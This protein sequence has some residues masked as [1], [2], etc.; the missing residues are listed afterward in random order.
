MGKWVSSAGVKTSTTVRSA[1]TD[2][3]GN[4]DVIIQN[5]ADA[6]LYIKIGASASSS[7]YD[8]AL[9]ACS[10]DGDGV[11][12]SIAIPNFH[13]SQVISAASTEVKYTY[14]YG[15]RC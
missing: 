7:D 4:I 15:I 2:L 10:A 5:Q 9:K 8:F 6:V 13:E 12:G 11:G 3:G 14:S 1:T